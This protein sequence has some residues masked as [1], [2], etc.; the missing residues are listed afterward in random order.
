MKNIILFLSLVSS[1]A[2]ADLSKTTVFSLN[3]IYLDRDYTDNGVS[4]QSKITDTDLRLMK[5]EKKWSY[6][7]I[8]SMSSN[9]SS[10][11]NRSSYGLSVVLYLD[12]H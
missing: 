5:V 4:S 7:A 8:Y 10:D 6:G 12:Q 11:S 1:S 9:D 2:F 3:T